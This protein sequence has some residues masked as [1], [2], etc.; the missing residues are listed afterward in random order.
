MKSNAGS[1]LA[2]LIKLLVA[3]KSM[4]CAPTLLGLGA[5][6]VP[7]NDRMWLLKIALLTSPEDGPW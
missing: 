1:H 6:L 4:T 3:G 2:N 5:H 7:E